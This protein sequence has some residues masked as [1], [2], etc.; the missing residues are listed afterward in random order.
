G[1]GMLNEPT[2]RAIKLMAR[3][4]GIFLDPTYSGKAFA[5]VVDSLES[6]RFDADNHVVFLHTGGTP[7]LFAYPELVNDEQELR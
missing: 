5:A 6:S 2:V 3:R 4:E 1:Y 7:S